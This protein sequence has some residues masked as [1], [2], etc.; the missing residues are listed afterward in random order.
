MEPKDWN[1]WYDL[2]KDTVE[3]FVERYGLDEV[4]SWH[5][6]VWNELWGMDYPGSYLPLYNASAMAVKAVDSEIKVGGP[7][8]MQ[9]GFLP[10][11]LNACKE[12]NFPV[13]FVS[14]H[15]Y[16]TDPNCTDEVVHA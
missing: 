11:F 12:S 8:T 3:H 9:L 1:D 6:E 15:F 16:P 14:S 5:F 7:A 13:D 2:I 4:R 10:D